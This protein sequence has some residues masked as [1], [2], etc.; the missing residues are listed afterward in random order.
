MKKEYDFSK[1]ERGAIEKTPK[2]KTRITIRL[3][4]DVISWFRTQVEEMGGGNYQ[5]M[6]ND[7]LREFIAYQQSTLEDNIRSVV[8]EEFLKLV[9]QLEFTYSPFKTAMNR[10]ILPEFPRV[11]IESFAE[12]S[13]SE[14]KSYLLANNAIWREFSARD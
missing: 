5:T 10:S 11:E 6:I 12:T 14:E 3:D 1:G 9:W 7:A 8:R 2:S 13:G 4:R